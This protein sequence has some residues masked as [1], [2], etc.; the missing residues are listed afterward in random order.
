[1]RK[2]L[3]LIKR[4]FMT[5]FFTKGFLIATIIGPFIIIG[6]A[7]FPV[8]SELL[9]SEY[10]AQI[11]YVDESG[12]MA[13][14]IE[15][16]FSD[17]LKNGDPKYRLTAISSDNYHQNRDPLLTAIEEDAI[18]GLLVIP[19]SIIDSNKVLFYAKSVTD[20]NMQQLLRRGLQN[21]IDKVRLV[22]AGLN[23]QQ[24]DSLTRSINLTTIKVSK[25]QEE[26]K[27]FGAEWMSA[28]VFLFFLYMTTILYGNTVM[29]GVLE[30]KTSRIFEVLLSSSNAF[31]LMMGKLFGVGSVGLAQYL[32]WVTTA[33]IAL[34]L[35]G[36]TSPALMNN[37]S[38][39][40]EMLIYF[41]LFFLLGYFQFSTLYAAVGSISSTQEDAQALSVP[42]TFLIVIPFLV[43]ITLGLRDPSSPI[44]TTLSILPFFAPMLMFLRIALSTPPMTE[45]ILSLAVNVVAIV[46]FVWIVAKIYRVGILMHGKRPNLPEV[47]RW[48]RYR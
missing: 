43:S 3:I 12:M 39:S 26:E 2:S 17:T 6:M 28:F 13:Q 33:T 14:A 8:I 25:G 18:D 27:G 19:E 16:A 20:I 42:V 24:I 9:G 30:E 40:G 1:M 38:L 11:S 5:K 21:E 34:T 36:S 4:E 46:F 31:Q 23:P 45:I 15:Q 47:L 37:I 10:S 41:V 44:A 29:R 48:I 35:V 7:L 22:E 32:I